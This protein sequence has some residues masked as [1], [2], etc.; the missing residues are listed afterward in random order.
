MLAVGIAMLRSYLL[1][2]EIITFHHQPAVEIF[3]GR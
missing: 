1:M 3:D 2:P